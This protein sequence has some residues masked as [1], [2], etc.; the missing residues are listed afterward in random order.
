MTRERVYSP[1]ELR[2]G[3][4]VEV[5]QVSGSFVVLDL[6]YRRTHWNGVVVAAPHGLRGVRG[7]G[8]CHLILPGLLVHIY[9]DAYARGEVFIRRRSTEDLLRAKAREATHG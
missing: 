9:G 8:T 5:R 7:D 3:N 2:E 6:L 4:R 1:D